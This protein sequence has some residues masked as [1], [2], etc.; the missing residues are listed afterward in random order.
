MIE[1][2]RAGTGVAAGEVSTVSPIAALRSR[3][4]A[5]GLPPIT[6]DD[7]LL[8]WSHTLAELTP[9]ASRRAGS[10]RRREPLRAPG[11]VRRQVVRPAAGSSISAEEIFAEIRE[12]LGGTSG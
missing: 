10:Q 2:A 4:S 6:T 11:R 5:D 8:E 12:R 3:H 1:P 9:R 7:E